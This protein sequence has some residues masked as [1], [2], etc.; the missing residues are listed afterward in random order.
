MITIAELLDYKQKVQNELLM[1]NAKIAVI[2]ELIA[3]EQAKDTPTEAYEEKFTEEN[4]E[5]EQYAQERVTDET[6]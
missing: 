1:A 3:T 6:Y 5:T 4:A 2:E